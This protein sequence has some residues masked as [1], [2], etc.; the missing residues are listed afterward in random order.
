[1]SRHRARDPDHYLHTSSSRS[2]RHDRSYDRGYDRG[3]DSEESQTLSSARLA[4][5]NR[6]FE[7]ARLRKS[8]APQLDEDYRRQDQRRR[9]RHADH[10]PVV[11]A[12]E[13]FLGVLRPRPSVNLTRS[14]YNDLR[15]KASSE[16]PQHFER[17]TT[18]S[19]RRNSSSAHRRDIGSRQSDYE[20]S[21]YKNHNSDYEDL[22]VTS[23]VKLFGE[24]PS[25]NPPPLPPAPHRSYSPYLEEV[26]RSSFASGRPES[27]YTADPIASNRYSSGRAGSV[28]GASSVGGD[29]STPG[30][31]RKLFSKSRRRD[32]APPLPSINS[33]FSLSGIQDREDDYRPSSRYQ[34][35]RYRED[36]LLPPQ[37]PYARASGGRGRDSYQSSRRGSTDTRRSYAADPFESPK[38][39]S[40]RTA[41]P[42]ENLATAP[43]VAAPPA[44]PV[45]PEMATILSRFSS[46]E[47]GDHQCKRGYPIAVFCGAQSMDVGGITNSKIDGAYALFFGPGHPQNVQQPMTE[48][49][50][51][52][53]HLQNP[54]APTVAATGR[55]A[56]LIATTRALQAVHDLYR[57]K[58]CAHICMDSAYVAKAW[59]SWIP[60]WEEE[61]WPG[62]EHIRKTYSHSGSGS[63]AADDGA[64]K[65]NKRL[66]DEDLL[67]ELAA[68][69]RL[70]A[71]AERKGTGAAHLYLIDRNANPANKPCRL[72]LDNMRIR[73]VSPPPSPGAMSPNRRDS[74][75]RSSRTDLVNGQGRVRDLPSGTS[76]KRLSRREEPGSRASRDIRASRSG[77]LSSSRRKDAVAEVDE[78]NMSDIATAPL[79]RRISAKSTASAVTALDED[80]TA[81]RPAVTAL[82]GV[83]PKNEDVDAETPA[84]PKGM[85]A[86]GLASAGALL[87]AGFLYSGLARGGSPGAEDSK[88]VEAAVPDEFDSEAEGDAPA[89]TAGK[90]LA[91]VEK[92]DSTKIPV[93][94]VGPAAQSSD[95]P[96]IEPTAPVIVKKDRRTSK[97]PSE[98]VSAV[99]TLAPAAAISSPT[100]DSKR[101]RSK[102][103][104]LV[105]EKQLSPNRKSLSKKTSDSAVRAAP[106]VVPNAV[107][108]EPEVEVVKP[109]PARRT[110]AE[111]KR[112][113]AAAT[114]QKLIGAAAP[115][116]V[117]QDL[118]S[119]SSEEEEDESVAPTPKARPASQAAVRKSSA[120]PV[121]PLATNGAS[122]SENM[123][124][125]EAEADVVP[126]ATPKK[127]GIFGNRKRAAPVTPVAMTL[128]VP[129]KN[130]KLTPAKRGSFFT[131]LRRGSSAPPSPAPALDNAASSPAALTKSQAAARAPESVVSAVETDVTEASEEAE[132][133]VEAPS[134][135]AEEDEEAEP[136]AELATPASPAPV[137]PRLTSPEPPSGGR[138]TNYGRKRAE[139]QAAAAL[140]A[141]PAV[142]AIPDQD[143]GR[144]A[145]VVTVD[146]AAESELAGVASSA[147]TNTES[148]ARV[149]IHPSQRGVR[150][151]A[152]MPATRQ[153]GETASLAP[154][155]KSTKSLASGRFR[156]LSSLGGRKGLGAAPEDEEWA[157]QLE[158]SKKKRGFMPWG[159]KGEKAPPVPAVPASYAAKTAKS[160]DARAAAVASPE[161]EADGADQSLKG[162][163]SLGIL[164]RGTNTVGS[165]KT[166]VAP[167]VAAEDSPLSDYDEEEELEEESELGSNLLAEEEEEQAAE[168]E[169][170][171]ES[172]AVSAL[173]DNEAAREVEEKKAAAPEELAPPRSRGGRILSFAS[174]SSAKKGPAASPATAA[175]Q[176]A[177]VKAKPAKEPFKFK[178]SF[179]K[180]V[181]LE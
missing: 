166:K 39:S 161:S 162:K 61:G 20:R 45:D 111:R 159:K 146:E 106:V 68:I 66:A 22:G 145:S 90:A 62:D 23:V 28:Y 10:S 89:Y 84:E 50:L 176:P 139:R 96:V 36:Y 73:G 79:G 5:H 154:S 122:A 16:V 180:L 87:S 109:A 40:R 70:Y 64:K 18:P 164:R 170:G 95:G 34:S 118:D 173:E 51:K 21:P 17:P 93:A 12:S 133:A 153:V 77:A 13:Q 107:E 158:G 155:N 4:E 49:E 177:A 7:K 48:G 32:E 174:P 38:R 150:K 59:G 85:L 149:P 124:D 175:S 142:T 136:V 78:S 152:S 126:L 138:L 69:R 123:T 74:N 135:I 25:Q 148:A 141:P 33:G 29:S 163:R 56:E 137:T 65:S 67:R 35:D 30:R 88:K 117:D 156:S 71:R 60:K 130:G 46:R 27:L 26:R 53:S 47:M 110:L 11:D 129:E 160:E 63:Q 58:A 44:E 91:P 37:V 75:R 113:A 104:D 6:A 42:A 9:R 147:G 24:R 127:S 167:V 165:K 112:A 2:R 178:K 143:S 172:E 55:R 125:S 99:P 151:Q 41:L 94:A 83:E 132:S 181:A 140:L 1:M 168:E 120:T 97:K 128:E 82:E 43:L 101:R 103:T 134:V 76:S 114:E 86:T 54:K 121:T 179:S 100:K 98:S 72:I 105:A 102:M 14:S 115:V 116:V 169:D 157:R 52:P 144:D 80:E 3:Y 171:D 131:L 119:S 19:R 108:E 8:S 57:G 15:G 92:G 31:R 81:A